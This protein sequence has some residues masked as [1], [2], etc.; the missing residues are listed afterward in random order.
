MVRQDAIAWN[1][2]TLTP[3]VVALCLTIYQFALY[4][5]LVNEPLSQEAAKRLVREVVATGTVTFTRHARDEMRK[6][7]MSETDVI[8]ILRGGV[9][10]P[11]EWEKGAWR[12][13]FETMK[14]AVVME[15]ASDTELVVITAWRFKS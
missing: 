10:R 6:D 4:L 11:A 13:R 7:S 12:Y 3:Q 9:C 15:L 1:W 2:P 8:N 14:F 5:L